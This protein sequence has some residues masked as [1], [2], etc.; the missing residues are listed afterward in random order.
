MKDI[1]NITK[2]QIFWPITALLLV[3][4]FNLFFT[5]GFFKVE[6]KDG[7]LFGSIIDIINRG[8]P[9]MLLSI[10]MTLVIATGGTDIS[11]GSVIAISA[12]VAASL[13][14]GQM[15][16]VDGV[17]EYVT[18]VPMP[19]AILA[20]LVV[21]ILLGLWNGTLIAKLGIQPIIATMI[22]MVAGRGIAQ[23]ITAGQII[24]IYYKPYFFFGGGYL[25]GLPFAIF[26]VGL[27]LLIIMLLIKKTALGL[28]IQASGCNASASKYAGIYVDR[29]KLIVYTL[30]GLCAGIAGVLI[31]S[32]IKSADA[33][34][35][36]LFIEL[37]AILA[38][39]MGGNSMTGGKFSI[40]ASIVG[41][42][43]IQSIT[44]TIYSIGVP[45]EITLVVKA[46]V[47]IMI[48]LLQSEEFRKLF[49]NTSWLQ[50]RNTLENK[51]SN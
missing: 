34:N 10:G 45:P 49:A 8:S 4:L 3:L 24:T 46:V 35:A 1:K 15:I 40:P 37:D 17:Q 23:L 2:N 13:V 33:N 43:V 44:T 6:V 5:P 14:G 50:R 16:F 29:I 39:A 26:I 20:T 9:L 25:L 32:N 30:S 28:F 42:L 31:S 21:A 11:V 22:L 38:V 41:A 36:G 51:I 12:A 27:V 7:H 19:L 47:V 18:L 48:C